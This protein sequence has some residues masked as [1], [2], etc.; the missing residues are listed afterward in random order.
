MEVVLEAGGTPAG[1]ALADGWIRGW[2]LLRSFSPGKKERIRT[3]DEE[4][5]GEEKVLAAR[6]YVPKEWI[7]PPLPP[8]LPP[9]PYGLGLVSGDTAARGTAPATVD[10]SWKFFWFASSFVGFGWEKGEVRKSLGSFGGRRVA[11]AFFAWR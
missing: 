1:S 7:P 3:E 4:G 6:K 2:L 9:P 10:G 5:G 11:T 8:S